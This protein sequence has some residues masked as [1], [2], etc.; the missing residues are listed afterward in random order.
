M[1]IKYKKL[2]EKQNVDLNTQSQPDPIKEESKMADSLRELISGLKEEY[3]SDLN[4]NDLDDDQVSDISESEIN[5]D[6]IQNMSS[7]QELE[8]KIKVSSDQQDKYA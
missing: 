4:V 7:N 8:N 3:F 6:E 5:L 1:L 2:R